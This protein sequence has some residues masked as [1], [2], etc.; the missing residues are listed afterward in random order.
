MLPADT[1]YRSRNNAAAIALLF[2]L[3]CALLGACSDGSDN[4]HRSLGVPGSGDANI[5]AVPAATLQGPVSGSPVLVST[6]FSLPGVG[7]EQAEYFVTGTASAYVNSNELQANGRWRVQADEQAQ[8]RTRIVVNRPSDPAVFN[9]TVIVEWLNV[10]AGFDSAP[11]WG[12]L[13]TELIRSGYAWVGVSAQQVGVDALVDGSAAATIPGTPIDDRYASLVHPG[14]AFSYDIYAQVTQALRQPATAA[15]WGGLQPQR[16]I[17]VGESQSAGRLLTYVNAFA[18][19]HALFEGYLIHSRTGG[20]APLKGGFGDPELP[21][22]EIVRV[23]DDLGVPVLMLQT[24]TDLFILG[25]WPSNQPDSEYFR[26]WEVAGSAHADLYTFLDNRFDIGTDPSVAAVIE[27][28]DPVPGIISCTVPVNAG[29]QHWV[30]KAAIAALNTWVSEG[31]APPRAQRLAV[32]GD[33]AA[34]RLD[35]LGNVRGG[36]R[37]P[38]VDAPIAVLS[39]EGQPQPNFDEIDQISVDEVDFCFLSGT[40]FLFDAATLGSLYESNAAYI[41][42]VN[43]A[44][45]DA[46]AR[47]FLLRADAELIQAHAAG[48]DIFAP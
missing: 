13:H 28:L 15:P 8:Y 22:P 43:A 46:V 34:F 19:L 6:F 20:S 47:G 9:G 32:D 27:V 10:S 11:D 41:E 30:A 39:G 37:T 3:G 25:S 2:T 26:L 4:V 5:I 42:A 29:P 21:T 36:I 1:P 14:D 24:E 17:A 40:T 38:Y 31:V 12:M 18:P 7:Y 45:E 23:R 48:T 44:A 33:A 35:A 16:F